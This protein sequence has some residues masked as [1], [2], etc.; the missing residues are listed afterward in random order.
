MTPQMPILPM[1][2]TISSL[3]HT[4]VLKSWDYTRSSSCPN[5]LKDSRCAGVYMKHGLSD[6]RDGYSLVLEMSAQ[7][8]TLRESNDINPTNFGPQRPIQGLV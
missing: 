1:R 8:R 2:G 3:T 4:E 7:R 6:R 5:G